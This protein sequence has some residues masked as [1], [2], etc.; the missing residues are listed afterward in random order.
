MIS[1]IYRKV[2]KGSRNIGK[3]VEKVVCGLV[4]NL[5][6]T[7]DVSLEGLLEPANGLVSNARAEAETK[8]KKAKCRNRPSSEVE[9]DQ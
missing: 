6:E 9:K 7:V 5:K 4:S 2:T 1:S 8:G 3:V